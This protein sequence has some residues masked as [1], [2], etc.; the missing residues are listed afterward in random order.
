MGLRIAWATVS[1]CKSPTKSSR[2]FLS[3]YFFSKTT[4]HNIMSL[5][6]CPVSQGAVV[7]LPS[8]LHT[9][10]YQTPATNRGEKLYRNP[11]RKGKTLTRSD[12][13]PNSNFWKV[14]LIISRHPFKTAHAAIFLRGNS[15]ECWGMECNT[16]LWG[17]AITDP[18]ASKPPQP[19][20]TGTPQRPQMRVPRLAL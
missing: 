11:E 2:G 7:S 8:S 19:V 9:T 12:P 15:L 1:P 14:V 5:S 17:H 20:S 16:G 10:S 4:R 3:Q 13:T 18:R 6:P